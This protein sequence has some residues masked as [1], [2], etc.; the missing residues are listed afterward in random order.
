[1]VVLYCQP[2]LESKW[3]RSEDSFFFFF[4]KNTEHFAN[5]LETGLECTVVCRQ[6]LGGYVD[7][8]FLTF[9]AKISKIYLRH[10]S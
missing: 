7:F 9:S 4:T 1:M 3:G 2:K 6:N 10:I 8:P 5:Q